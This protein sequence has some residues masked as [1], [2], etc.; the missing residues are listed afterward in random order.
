MSLFSKTE[1]IFVPV[2]VVTTY[3][4]GGII[5]IILALVFWQVIFTVVAAIL[6]VLLL[7]GLISWYKNLSEDFSVGA[8]IIG[9]LLIIAIVGGLYAFVHQKINGNDLYKKEAIAIES[10]KFSKNANI[11]QE[12]SELESNISNEVP[13]E[14]STLNLAEI[15]KEPQEQA[16]ID[17]SKTNELTTQSVTK[18][19]GVVNETLVEV[20]AVNLTETNK[21]SQ[22]QIQ[23]DQNKTNESTT[24]SVIKSDGVTNKIPLKETTKTQK[25]T[26]E[27]PK[28]Q[29]QI[30][31]SK[32]TTPGGVIVSTSSNGFYSDGVNYYYK[33][34]DNLHQVNDIVFKP[35]TKI[36]K[37]FNFYY[38]VGQEILQKTVVY[39]EDGK[40]VKSITDSVVRYDKIS[41]D[42]RFYI[43]SGVFLIGISLVA[44]SLLKG[45]SKG[46]TKKKSGLDSKSI[47]IAENSQEKPTNQIKSVAVNNEETN[48]EKYQI[49]LYFR[50]LDGFYNIELNPKL[51][52]QNIIKIKNGIVKI[53]E[54]NT[55]VQ[56]GKYK[57]VKIKVSDDGSTIQSISSIN[58]NYVFDQLKGFDYKINKKKYT[59]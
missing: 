26:N 53:K 56:N 19:D 34:N 35:N 58:L 25:K 29:I 36:P 24:Q 54:Q 52:E 6:A 44:F 48:T 1:I 11:V 59:I 21:E 47:L 37:T 55:L 12:R 20:S 51:N 40:M 10:E 3:P 27:E 50:R 13:V 4:V 32:T 57:T 38:F 2:K 31:E 45:R 16:Q 41:V 39:N 33:Y 42:P 18:S 5:M 17:E 22:D 30:E 49:K 23:I 15:N 8:K 28:N 9:Y 43:A 7:I 46:I 14:E